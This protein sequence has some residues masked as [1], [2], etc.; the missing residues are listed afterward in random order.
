MLFGTITFD[1]NG[2]PIID[3]IYLKYPENEKSLV[4]CSS[5]EAPSVWL[6]DDDWRPY[7]G[8]DVDDSYYKIKDKYEKHPEEDDDFWEGKFE[9]NYPEYY[10]IVTYNKGKITSTK[11]ILASKYESNG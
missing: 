3:R 11:Y 2:L 8:E 6:E 4:V 7:S 5:S 1:W 10:K 9:D